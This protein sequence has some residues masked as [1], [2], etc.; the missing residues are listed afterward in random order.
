M[1]GSLALGLGV[2]GIFLPVLPTTPFLLLA[3][4]CY[5]R[6][7]KKL[8]RWLINHKVL[9]LYVR[10]F[11]LY[12]AISLKAKIISIAALWLVIFS[13]VVFFVDPLWLRILLLGIAVSVSLY[14]LRFRTLTQD[15]IDEEEKRYSEGK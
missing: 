9:G 5:V 4:A 15:I 8:Y 12:K 3:A 7:S 13:T 6:S 2:I 1:G 10:S 11:I 14:L